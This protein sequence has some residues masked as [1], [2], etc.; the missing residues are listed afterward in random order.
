MFKKLLLVFVALFAV[1]TLAACDPT[2]E[3][4]ERTFVADGVYTAFSEEL[5]NAGGP[6]IT[7]VS[8][9]IENDEITAFYI[10]VIQSAQTKNAEDVVTGFAFNAQSKKELGYAYRMHGQRSLTEAE[11]ITWLEENEKLEWFEQAALIE[12][13]MVENGP[14]AVTKTEDVIDNI[15]T[16]TIKDAYTV[17]AAQAVQN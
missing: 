1:V 15:A 12:A 16:V 11:Y 7:W 9:T 5:T 6:Q 3:P 13:F 2:E 17:L 14:A 8:V 4:V 10:D